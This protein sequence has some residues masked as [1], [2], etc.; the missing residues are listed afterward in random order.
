MHTFRCLVEPIG[1]SAP[2]TAG[3]AGACFPAPAEAGQAPAEPVPP[4]AEQA[5]A[6][7]HPAGT[8]TLAPKGW[9][10]GWVGLTRGQAAAQCAASTN[11][12][13]SSTPAALHGAACTGP[14][15][16]QLL[17]VKGGGAQ[18]AVP[19]MCSPGC[20]A[21][22]PL[23]VSA[24]TLNAGQRNEGAAPQGAVPAVQRVCCWCRCAGCWGQ[25]RGL[26]GADQA[27]LGQVDAAGCSSSSSS[28]SQV[29]LATVCSVPCVVCCALGA[30]AGAPAPNNGRQRVCTGHT[31]MSPHAPSGS[32]NAACTAT[33]G[34][35]KEVSRQAPVVKRHC[36]GVKLN[37]RLPF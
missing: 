33:A 7:S 27:N 15:L 30:A 11:S 5:A 28:K 17:F 8:R 3:N 14:L 29:A 21:A 19:A 6:P 9:V 37:P 25:S 12:G 18:S 16:P 2:N 26:R 32:P 36:G 24:S 23:P 1:R 13:A 4:P 35:D 22:T 34:G 10:G 20:A 31:R